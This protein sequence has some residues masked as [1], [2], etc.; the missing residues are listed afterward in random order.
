MEKK[1]SKIQKI[2]EI[3]KKESENNSKEID[4]LKVEMK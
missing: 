4:F 2:A 3:S 1:W